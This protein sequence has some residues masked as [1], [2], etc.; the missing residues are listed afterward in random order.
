MTTAGLKIPHPS[1]D[2][3]DETA[4]ATGR[5]ISDRGASATLPTRIRVAQ[6]V[7]HHAR[8][9]FISATFIVYLLMRKSGR[10]KP[11]LPLSHHLSDDDTR[12]MLNALH[13]R[14]CPSPHPRSSEAK[15]RCGCPSLNSPRAQANI[16]VPPS[17]PV[18]TN[19]S[20]CLLRLSLPSH[21]PSQILLATE[22]DALTRVLRGRRC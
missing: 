18:I 2:A 1:E 9:Q 7:A 16:P 3:C 10:R 22:S 5:P 20:R 11:Y 19:T 15:K 21:H 8:R 14:Q 6:T 4:S 17:S 13:R 12:A